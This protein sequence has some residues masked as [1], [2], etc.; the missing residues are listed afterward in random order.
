MDLESSPLQ[1]EYS[2]KHTELMMK[3]STFRALI[4][5]VSLL[6]VSA[7]LTA[8][9]ESN[10]PIKLWVEGPASPIDLKEANGSSFHLDLCIENTTDAEIVLWPFLDVEISDSDGRAID[11]STNIGRNGFRTTD[12]ILEG[13]RFQTVQPGQVHKIEINLKRY[14]YDSKTITGWTLGESG[15]YEIKL[16]YK[17]DRETVKRELGKGCRDIDN[18]DHPWNRA[19]EAKQDISFE[20]Q[21]R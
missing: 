19:V 2:I 12:S 20:L 15:E 13:I 18:A 4:L 8:Q 5:V 6:G 9:D 16:S 14:M 1:A 17:F 10:R 7:H 3:K 11:R 21:V